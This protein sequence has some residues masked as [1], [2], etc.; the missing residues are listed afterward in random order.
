MATQVV[1]NCTLIEQAYRG[2]D[3]EDLGDHMY[4]YLYMYERVLCHLGALVLEFTDT[5]AECDREFVYRCWQL[6]SLHFWGERE[7]P[8]PT[9]RLRMHEIGIPHIPKCLRHLRRL[10]NVRS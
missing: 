1:E 3:I 7:R 2:D 5:W 4:N 10:F 6:Y 9:A 8:R